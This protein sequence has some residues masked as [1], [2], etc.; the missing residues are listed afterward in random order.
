MLLWKAEKVVI[1]MKRAINGIFLGVKVILIIAVIFVV[2]IILLQRIFD[3]NVT[4]GGYR[5]FTVVTGS[6]EPDYGVLDVIV[7]REIDHKKINVGDDVVY[8]GSEGSFKDKI[9]THRVIEVKTEGEDVYFLTQGIASNYVDPQISGDQIFGVV[10]F[11]SH[12]LSIISNIVSHPLGFV[13]LIFVPGFI[14]I[15]SE[16]MDKVKEEDWFVYEKN[17]KQQ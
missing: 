16:V 13:F 7:S 3:N 10:L 2:S 8:L 6:M 17:S 14:L 12:T 11:K 4:I 5:I 15:A 9:V 1:K